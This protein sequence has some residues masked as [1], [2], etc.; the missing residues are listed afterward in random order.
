MTLLAIKNCNVIYNVKG[1]K[2]HAVNDVSFD[3]E[4]QD[5][6]G[7]VGES[8]SGKST[9]AMMILSLLP[10]DITEVTGKIIFEEKD[11][12]NISEKEYNKYR[13]TEIAAVFQKS[14]NSLSP[15]HKIGSQ[16]IKIYKVHY[17]K[18]SNE[19]AKKRIL[20]LFEM[21][22]LP[23]RVFALYQHELS[24]G[25]MQRV[26]ISLSLMHN[27]KLIIMDEATTALDVVTESQILDEII[28]LEQKLKI[29]RLMITHDMSIVA[30]TCKKIAVMYAGCL[31]E[32]GLVKDIISNP[33]HPYTIGLLKSF[34][35]F[36][37]ERTEISS[38][39][40]NLP[41]LSD[42]PVGCV[43]APRCNLAED[44]CFKIRPESILY[45]KGR[46]IACHMVGGDDDEVL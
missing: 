38:M 39:K 29:T 12:L 28:E 7:I 2:V 10:K 21:V 1:V 17:P 44:I 27:P 22:N 30:N 25:M 37:G 23:E 13:W 40:G 45:E 41:D 35:N 16:M 46:R 43:F 42:L 9:L 26:S 31:L 32:Y 5:S 6:V 4:Q 24:G 34:P 20:E 11:I 33:K 15:V 14:M 3:V 19:E 18:S 8:G 36:K